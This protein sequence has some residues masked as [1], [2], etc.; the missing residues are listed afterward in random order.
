MPLPFGGEFAVA[1]LTRALHLDGERVVM[2]GSV[3]VHADKFGSGQVVF[4]PAEH[5]SKR[6]KYFV[7]Q[8]SHHKQTRQFT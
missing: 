3:E 2:I 7:E 8:I 4:I 5:P 6:I 1:A